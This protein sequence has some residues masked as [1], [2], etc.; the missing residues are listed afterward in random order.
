MVDSLPHLPGRV[1]QLVPWAPPVAFGESEER[2][3]II[4]DA[5]SD[6]EVPVRILRAEVVERTSP[7][8]KLAFPACPGVAGTG[9]QANSIRTATDLRM[10]KTE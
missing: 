3:S 1:E 9:G 2:P 5:L 8:A 6:V 7:R 4:A 10:S